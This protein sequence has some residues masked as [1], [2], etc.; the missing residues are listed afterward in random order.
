MVTTEVNQWKVEAI[1]EMNGGYYSVV[2]KSKRV[3]M[4]CKLKGVGWIGKYFYVSGNNYARKEV[5]YCCVALSE[6]ATQYRVQLMKLLD[7]YGSRKTVKEEVDM[8]LSENTNFLKLFIKDKKD[9]HPSKRSRVLQLQ[10]NDHIT[11][12]GPYVPK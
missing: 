3:S 1:T 4:G 10:P 9:I 8:A 6:E 7:K 2:F 5:H 12:E 11:L